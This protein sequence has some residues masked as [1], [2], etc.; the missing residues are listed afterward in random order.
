MSKT[1]VNLSQ[2]MRFYFGDK[3]NQ[4]AIREVLNGPGNDFGWEELSKF[5]DAWLSA[6]KIRVEYWRF[7]R[8]AWAR[9]WGE[10]VRES[11]LNETDFLAYEMGTQW[12]GE[13]KFLDSVWDYG[14]GDGCLYTGF[15][16]EGGDG[17]WEAT[18]GLW[19]YESELRLFFSIWRNGGYILDVSR[20]GDWFKEWDESWSKDQQ[21]GYITGK[22]SRVK[23]SGIG[24][25][26][27]EVDLSPLCE[28]AKI[29]ANK[30]YE[31]L[32]GKL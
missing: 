30:L 13:E 22:A 2:E 6:Q 27:S 32:E 4:A 20:K 29:A 17:E 31:E 19:G 18:L 23:L 14:G 5:Y 24:E 9:I 26:E 7:M 16:S 1:V 28:Q 10:A 15:G 3:A 21:G 11:S 8:E 12:Y 25:E